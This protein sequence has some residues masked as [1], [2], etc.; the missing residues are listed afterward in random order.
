MLLPT[1]N[2][3]IDRTGAPGCAS[4]GRS[5]DSA[6]GLAIAFVTFG[7]FES[8]RLWIIARVAA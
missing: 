6:N 7:V 1:H 5:L 4:T 8:I 2:E 3:T